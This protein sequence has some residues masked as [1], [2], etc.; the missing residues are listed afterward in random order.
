MRRLPSFNDFSPKIIGDVRQPLEILDRLAPDWEAVVAEWDQVFFKSADN[1]RARTNIPA[2]LTSLKL[3]TRNPLALTN[4]GQLILSAADSVEAAQ[5]MILHVVKTL[6][7]MAVIDAVHSINARGEKC[8]KANLKLELESNGI[9]GLSNA[10]TDH[11]TLLNWMTDSGI[12]TRVGRGNPEPDESTMKAALGITS[13][14]RSSFSELPLNQQIFLQV[15]RR[16]AENHSDTALPAKL[17]IDE[18]LRNHRARFDDDQIRAKVVKP[19]AD[20]GWLE[21]PTSNSGGRGGKSGK[22]IALPKLLDIPIDAILPDFEQVVPADLRAK[23]NLPPMEVKRL[24]ESSK[25]FDR[26]LGLELLALK[27]IL[28]IGLEPRAFRL[29]SRDTAYAEVDLTAEGKNLLFSRWNFQ[30]KCI[31][32]RVSLGDVAKEV[33]LAIY[34]K[35]HVVAVVTTSDFTSAAIDYVSEITRATHLQFLLINGTVVDSYLDKGPTALLDHV[36]ANAANVMAQKR[37]QPITPK[38][39]D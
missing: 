27:M 35:A 14:E 15:L 2:T 11:T 37:G 21:A 1:G 22:I 17:I 10:T 26:G 36:A 16:L 39:E 18:C 28:D 29:R 23:I 34:S 38:E 32:G 20:A 24:L 13:S 9:E 3:M 31:S 25:K 8:S 30:C 19:L 12:F 6:N 5:R 33:G 7:G 4:S